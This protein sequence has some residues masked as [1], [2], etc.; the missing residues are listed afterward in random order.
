MWGQLVL[1]RMPGRL[2]LCSASPGPASTGRMLSA[3]VWRITPWRA[4]SGPNCRRASPPSTGL[5]LPILASRLRGC[6]PACSDPLARRCRPR[7]LA[8]P[9]THRCTVGRTLLQG[10]G[11]PRGRRAGRTGAGPGAGDLPERQPHQPRHPLAPVLAAR[12]QSWPRCLPTSWP[13]RSTAC[14]K[15]TSWKGYGPCSSTRT[16]HPLAGPAGGRGLAG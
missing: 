9:G 13:S 5:T 15:G 14:S 12:R 10:V 2:G 16:N 4:A 1:S 7:A 11:T 3:W 8:P 6:W